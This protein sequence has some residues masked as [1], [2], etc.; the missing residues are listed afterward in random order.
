[1]ALALKAL[2][3]LPDLFKTDNKEIETCRI[4]GR[5]GEILAASGSTIY[6][7]T[8]GSEE[9]SLWW[10]TKG[11][12]IRSIIT[13][14]SKTLLAAICAEEVSILGLPPVVRAFSA[15]PRVVGTITIPQGETVLKAFWNP[16]GPDDSVLVL[17]NDNNTVRMYDVLT[18]T[19]QPDYEHTFFQSQSSGNISLE[20][21]FI[22][23]DKVVSVC[24]G[25]SSDSFG[26]LTLYALSDSGDVY[27]LCPFVPSRFVISNED[28]DRMLDESAEAQLES[29]FKQ[30]YSE[31]LSW[32][33]E[34]WRQ[35][36]SSSATSTPSP[37]TYA[38]QD[39]GRFKT[40]FTVVRPNRSKLLL[41]GPFVAQP[42][43]PALY[44]GEALDISAT[45]TKCMTVLAVTMSNQRIN[46]YLQDI[47]L[48]LQW[49]SGQLTSSS[50]G[51]LTLALIES[52]DLT[53]VPSENGT[54]HKKH[55]VGFALPE[56]QSC[57]PSSQT[58]KSFSF[59]QRQSSQH[60]SLSQQSSFGNGDAFGV[61]F[62]TGSQSQ[63]N[64][65]SQQ[66]SWAKC[67]SFWSNQYV[68]YIASSASAFSCD[69]QSW[70]EPLDRAIETGNL[71]SVK[72]LI[73][74]RIKGIHTRLVPDTDTSGVLGHLLTYRPGG[75]DVVYIVTSRSV[76][77]NVD[78]DLQQDIGGGP[79]KLI[80][81][82]SQDPDA[83]QFEKYH[84]Q[85]SLKAKP[86]LAQQSID[87][88]DLNVPKAPRDVDTAAVPIVDN[89]P[90]NIYFEQISTHFGL[91]F[92][93]IDKAGLLIRNRL[94]QQKSELYT[95]LK[96]LSQ[97]SKAVRQQNSPIA[98][99]KEVQ[100]RQ[101]TIYQRTK[102]LLELVTKKRTLALSK[103]EE[104]WIAELSRMDQRL[105]S[106]N[107]GVALENRIKSTLCNAD[108][109]LDEASSLKN[110]TI[111]KAVVDNPHFNHNISGLF[112]MVENEEKVINDVQSQLHEML[113]DMSTLN[114]HNAAD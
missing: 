34:I 40:C 86:F 20:T 35:V 48:D 109:V 33:S 96:Q 45:A 43:P 95:Q 66:S 27:G 26:P 24:L 93:K 94:R 74:D 70:A 15:P 44:S 22:D 103:Q 89:L 81:D 62:G 107:G 54:H 110:A 98:K 104:S 32:I 51:K 114:I 64:T 37:K 80:A 10:S 36:H 61:K 58:Q 55:Q 102:K 19:L 101:Q 105:V 97:L 92:S 39:G 14:N 11:A 59:G 65:A 31:Q 91:Q 29:E 41:Q 23:S 53:T 83:S 113:K 106:T 46:F 82:A 47:S 90:N 68:L 67:R 4:D 21:S 100:D 1:M 84:Y 18:S 2:H 25:T 72:T 16:I 108:H 6:R 76:Y 7:S 69:I 60:H 13:N 5:D 77:M 79:T 78:D 63:P 42:F 30:H 52:V 88:I 28:L 3:A 8:H 75:D 50:L 87:D 12:H 38:V 73:N 85:C 57:M 111:S 17:L 71:E 56:R 99:I 9:W 112:L 49:E